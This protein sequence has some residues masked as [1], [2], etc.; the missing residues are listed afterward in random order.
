[1]KQFYTTFEVAKICQVSPGS[2]VRWI[3]EGKVKAALTG[4]GHHRISYEQ[5]VLFLKQLQMPLPSELDLGPRILIVDDEENVRR[6]IRKV[7]EDYFP[8]SAVDEAGDGFRAGWKT[9]SFRPQLVILDMKLPG[10]DGMEVCR[11][12]RQFEELKGIKILAIS[13]NEALETMA[14]QAGSDD[15]LQKPFSVDDLKKKI[16]AHKTINKGSL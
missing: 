6:F 11:Y 7:I 12:I 2:V 9:H 13:G 10:V 15:F 5:L 14:R 4:G 8:D 16:L 1:M 3:H